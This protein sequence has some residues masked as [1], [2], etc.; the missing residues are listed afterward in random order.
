ML[1]ITIRKNMKEPDTKDN[2]ILIDDDFDN[3]YI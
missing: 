3:N 2:Q 1:T